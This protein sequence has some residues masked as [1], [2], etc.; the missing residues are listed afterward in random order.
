ME[1][2]RALF[3]HELPAFPREQPLTRDDPHHDFLDSLDG[4]LSV[5]F[6]RL[7][8][9]YL[10]GKQHLADADGQMRRW[11][12]LSPEGKVEHI[13]RLAAIFDQP[14]SRFTEAVHDALDSQPL[15]TDEHACLELCYR[16]AR[17]LRDPSPHALPLAPSAGTRSAYSTDD[18]AGRAA[19][20]CD[21]LFDTDRPQSQPDHA[22]QRQHSR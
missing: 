10:N 22:H 18:T 17:Q 5:K 9:D 7:L 20:L 11:P 2:Q 6:E 21:Q 19:A 8:D 3:D 14:L 13:A 15:R 16:Y 12:E 4:V 1:S